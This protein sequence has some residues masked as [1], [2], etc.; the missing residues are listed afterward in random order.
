MCFP[1]TDGGHSLYR[2]AKKEVKRSTSFK[3]INSD[4]V[5]SDDIMF[6]DD[7]EAPPRKPAPNSRQADA[8]SDD[9]LE[10]LRKRRGPAYNSCHSISSSHPVVSVHHCDFPPQQC[11]RTFVRNR[12]IDGEVKSSLLFR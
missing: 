3:D 9:E 1:Y 7:D 4:D 5:N 8:G 6:S 10:Q 12:K 11:A 2:P